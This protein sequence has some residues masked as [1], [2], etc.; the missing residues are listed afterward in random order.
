[1]LQLVGSARNLFLMPQPNRELSSSCEVVLLV[2]ERNYGIT[3]DGKNVGSYDEMK[4]L[5]F[6][7][8]R[9]ALRSLICQ[10][11]KFEDEMFTL[12]D[13]VTLDGD[14]PDS[15]F[16]LGGLGREVPEPAESAD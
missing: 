4:E 5:R 2:V 8:T 16:E 1:M 6:H 9:P 7:T 10:L 11:A 14:A 12:E 3:K 15:L 13:C